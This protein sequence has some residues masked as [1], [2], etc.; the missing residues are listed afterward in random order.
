MKIFFAVILNSLI[1]SNIYSQEL[2]QTFFVVYKGDTVPYY[3]NVTICA[4]DTATFFS[5]TEWEPSFWLWYFDGG[6][7]DTTFEKSPS[8]VYNNIGLFNVSLYVGAEDDIYDTAYFQNLP[9]ITVEYCPP[10]SNFNFSNEICMDDCFNTNSTSS[11]APT[12]WQWTFTSG[13]P[14]E[15]NGEQPPE[16]CYDTTGIFPITL[17]TTNPAG[18][19]TLVQYITVNEMPEGEAVTQNLDMN[20]GEFILLESCAEGAFYQWQPTEYLS[21]SDCADA[22]TNPAIPFIQYT[23]TVSNENGCEVV[24]TYNI[25][26]NNLPEEIF[27]PN[28]F[29]PNGDGINDVFM[30]SQKF[31]Q[32]Q[33]FLIYDRWG[34]MMFNTENVFDGWDGTY[35]NQKVNSGVYMYIIKYSLPGNDGIK[36]KRGNVTVLR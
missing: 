31:I 4:G 16:I 23:N 33:S 2:Y 17:I 20:F 36:I 21:C 32:L 18:S 10:I 8:V 34:E 35:E 1:A 22:L 5:D 30:I 25:T 11:Y 15:W 29:T 19:D 6:I 13:S 28:S 9:L 3:S 7:P 12:T 14:P 24:C 27:M 26:V